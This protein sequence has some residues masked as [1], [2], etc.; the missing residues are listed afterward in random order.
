[1]YDFPE[2]NDFN[3]NNAL[4]NMGILLVSVSVAEKGKKDICHEHMLT[5][6]SVLLQVMLTQNEIL[7]W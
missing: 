3:E 7:K 6:S 1:M 5:L 2:C 4:Y